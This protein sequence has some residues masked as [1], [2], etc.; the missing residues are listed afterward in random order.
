MK[1]PLA[2]SSVPY[3]FDFVLALEDGQYRKTI[4]VLFSSGL[5]QMFEDVRHEML[6][7]HPQVAPSTLPPSSAPFTS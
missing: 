4:Q 7:K 2:F 1:R 3:C 5:V 6:A